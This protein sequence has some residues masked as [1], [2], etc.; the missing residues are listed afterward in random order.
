MYVNVCVTA[1]NAIRR[2]FNSICQRFGKIF[3]LA[4][5]IIVFSLSVGR[6]YARITGEAG[7]AGGPLKLNCNMLPLLIT[8][9][10]DTVGL[11]LNS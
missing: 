1:D 11:P 6:L 4:F 10:G 5:N 7:G 2:R 9:N 8:E 3:M